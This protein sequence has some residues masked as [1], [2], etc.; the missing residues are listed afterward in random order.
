[1]FK[2]AGAAN[3]IPYTDFYDVKHYYMDSSGSN[4]SFTWTFDIIDEGFN[5][6]TQDVTSASVTLNLSDDR[7]DRFPW[8]EYAYLDL[9]EN[10]FFWEADSSDINFVVTSIMTLS[11][12]GRIDATLRCLIGDFYFNDATLYVDG[13]DPILNSAHA[14]EPVSLFMFGTGLIGLAFLGRKKFFLNKA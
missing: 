11:D 12:Y 8:I 14:K 2:F 1:M 13:T 10:Y 6:E 4:S 7:K 3:A 9:G 5:P